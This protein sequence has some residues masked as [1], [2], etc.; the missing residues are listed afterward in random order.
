M[1][2]WSSVL[3]VIIV[4]ALGYFVVTQAP[5]KENTTTTENTEEMNQESAQNE[6]S[7]NSQETTMN[8]QQNLG[9]EITK[10]GSGEPIKAGQTA[11]MNYTGRLE[12]GT[13]FDSNVDPKFNHVEPFEFVLGQN[14]VIQ[15]WEQGV[16]GMKMGEKRVLTIPATLGYGASGIPGVIP[17]GATLVF[18]IELVSI[19]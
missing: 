10:E 8:T 19:K 5:Q 16:L 15:G 1:K 4:G 18:D 6:Q 17:G 3:I 14:R 7:D 2:T 12:D 13:A 9:I 11:V